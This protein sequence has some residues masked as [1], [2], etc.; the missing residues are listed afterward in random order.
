[1]SAFFVVSKKSAKQLPAKT[2]R[3]SHVLAKWEKLA[4]FM[5]KMESQ[6]IILLVTMKSP[7]C[8][9][10][11]L[12]CGGTLLWGAKQRSPGMRRPILQGIKSQCGSKKGFI[13]LQQ[14]T[15]VC[16]SCAQGWGQQQG[17]AE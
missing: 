2:S 3:V 14:T 4:Q 7:P 9:C 6:S 15:E 11:T 16:D 5:E 12:R 8:A 13:R 17:A 1:M 10:M